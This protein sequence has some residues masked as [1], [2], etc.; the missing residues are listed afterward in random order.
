MTELLSAI[1]KI[2]MT[3]ESS[4]ESTTEDMSE[5]RMRHPENFIE[6]ERRGRTS[7]PLR[8]K[9][10]IIAVFHHCWKA[11]YRMFVI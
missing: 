11:Q 8:V 7:T 10:I 4:T 2:S 9:G 1:L 3:V 6:V 5:M